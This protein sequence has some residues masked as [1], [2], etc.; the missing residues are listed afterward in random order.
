MDSIKAI[1]SY[2]L[3]DY[4]VKPVQHK[5]ETRY[6]VV[7]PDGTL[8]NYGFMYKTEGEAIRNRDNCMAFCRDRRDGVAE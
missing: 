2:G 7:R 6:V 3:M 5:G 4:H 8:V 1:Q